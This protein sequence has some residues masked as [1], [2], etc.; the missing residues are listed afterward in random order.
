MNND[1]W[2][3]KSMMTFLGSWAELKHDT[4]LYSKQPYCYEW[5]S[6]TSNGYVEPYPDVYSRLNSLVGLMKEGLA[7]RGLLFESFKNALDDFS[8]YLS[9]FTSASIKELENKDLNDQE[10]S[11]IRWA[12]DRMAEHLRY[13]TLECPEYFSSADSRMALIADVQTDPN[14]GKVLEVGVGNPLR[15]YVIVQ[16]KNGDLKFTKGGTYSYYEF[17]VKME[18]RLTDEMWQEILDDYPPDMPNWISEFLIVHEDIQ[19]MYRMPEFWVM[20]EK[21]KMGKRV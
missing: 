6:K 21:V 10:Y 3:I 7:A 2:V 15:I 18:N 16:T 9:L 1:L 14:S 5:S 13:I 4:I 8:N 12:A 11:A 17:K 20:V 19:D